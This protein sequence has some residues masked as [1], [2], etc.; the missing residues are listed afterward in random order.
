MRRVLKTLKDTENE[1]EAEKV[2]EMVILKK[3]TI[4]LSIIDQNTF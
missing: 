2:N 4:R 3:I 1:V